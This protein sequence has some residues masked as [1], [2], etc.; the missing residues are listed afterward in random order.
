MPTTGAMP[1][2]TG[3][4]PSL[5]IGTTTQGDPAA[6]ADRIMMVAIIIILLILK[7]IKFF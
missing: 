2:V 5:G 4:D 1:D 6:A 3:G 7:K